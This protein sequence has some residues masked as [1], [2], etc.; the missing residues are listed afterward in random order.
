MKHNGKY[1][2][3]YVAH[4]D[5]NE[6]I[7]PLKDHLL[8]V[9]GLCAKNASKV[10]IADAGTI[11]GLLH[12]FGKYSS[13]FQHYIFSACG[14]IDQDADGY[15]AADQMKGKIDHSTAGAQV[16][17]ELSTK[18][19]PS[20]QIALQILSV[21]I[22]S[23][24]SGLI[25]LINP[26]GQNEFLRRMRKPEDGSHYREV[27]KNS[28]L[29]IRQKIT[30][31]ILKDD[32]LN[33]IL[34]ILQQI[35]RGVQMANANRAFFQSGLFV[36]ML[37]SCLIDADRMDTSVFMEPFAKARLS[38]RK[39]VDWEILVSRLNS[40]LSDYSSCGV[41]N[42]IDKIRRSVSE[43]CLAK[44]DR[45]TGIFTLTVP[46]GGGK[47]LSSL[48]FALNHAAKHN[49][50]RIFYILP[51]TS[52]I[53]QNADVVR[54]ILE[55]KADDNE[56]VV[57]EH[58]SNIIP[59]LINWKTKMLAETWD[60]QVIFTTT[61]QFLETLFSGGTRSARRMH[62]LARSVIIFDEIQ[63]L[64]VKT[65]HL[66][67]NAINFLINLC[68]SSVVLCTATQPLLNKVSEEKGS[69]NFT[70]EN[71]IIENPTELFDSLKRVNVVPIKKDGGWS[72]SE[73]ASMAFKE[74]MISGSCLVVVNT[75]KSAKNI[76]QECIKRCE[77][78]VFHLSTNMC[79]AHRMDKL[80]KIKDQ[81]ASNQ[82]IICIS[83]QLIEAGVDV[84][85][86]SVIRFVAGIDSIVQ[87]A[88][89]CNRNMKR[90]VGN[91]FVVNPAEESIQNLPD[92]SKG[93]EI[94][95][96]I[97][98]EMDDP[99]GNLP[100]DLIHPDVLKRYYQ[101]YF[102]ER[103]GEMSYN[104]NTGVEDTLLNLL[105]SNVISVGEYQRMNNNKPGIR[106]CQAFQTAGEHFKVID[107]NTT[108]IIVPY[109]AGDELIKDLISSNAIFQKGILLKKSQRYTVNVYPDVLKLLREAEAISELQDIQ[110]MMLN[111]ARYYHPDFGLVTEIIQDYNSIII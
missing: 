38:S 111:D 78:Q 57:F 34:N 87:A 88:G 9:S 86:G 83:T 80:Q 53:D 95:H 6:H 56:M 11:I 23:H 2:D 45:S 61:V 7:Q 52:I 5:K 98:R 65:V 48:R 4:I 39:P 104:V 26:L 82:P 70:M 46:T 16:L 32:F 64:P 63:T 105:G 37:F 33:P 74:A 8:N 102:Y 72:N 12:D 49:L 55:I 19:K 90:E 18:V 47:T 69:L 110:V 54:K 35:F 59:E 91:V 109:L 73:I 76:F 89:R 25:N 14:L 97:L 17:W 106:L 27:E 50:D 68:G 92:I 22:A 15:V 94:T 84:D 29:E 103:S 31:L 3:E 66:F 67:C 100:N 93:V 21:C 51:Y 62:Q 58:H 71:E 24:H 101:Y 10:G 81:L 30:D 107:A 60:A 44:S 99:Q 79:P 75:K 43:V 28:D 96:R 108:G 42:K 13:S 77:V 85:F 41:E 36:R 1:S 40:K 20:Y